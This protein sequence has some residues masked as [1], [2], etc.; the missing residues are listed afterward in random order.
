MPISLTPEVE[1]QIRE[2]V[3]SGEYDSANEVV[4]YAMALLS[5]EDEEYSTRL[6]AL[7]DEIQKGID[8]LDNGRYSPIEEAFARIEARRGMTQP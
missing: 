4:R 3:E 8:D 5:R 1:R 6:Q 7:R 2:K